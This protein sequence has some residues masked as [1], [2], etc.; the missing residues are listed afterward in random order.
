MQARIGVKAPPIDFQVN[1]LKNIADI[2]KSPPVVARR[3]DDWV[4]SF[5]MFK[6]KNKIIKPV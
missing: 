1:N 6:P 4:T 3:A 5:E 2:K